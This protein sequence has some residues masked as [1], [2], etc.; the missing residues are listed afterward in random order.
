MRQTNV[1]NFWKSII[2]DLFSK[3]NK[4]LAFIPIILIPIFFHFSKNSFVFSALNSLAILLIILLKNRKFNKYFD[5]ILTFMFINFSFLILRVENYGNLIGIL[6]GLVSI[7]SLFTYYNELFILWSIGANYLTG[8]I[9]VLSFVF[10]YYEPNFRFKPN[11]KFIFI[12]IV[13]S[14]F[15]LLWLNSNMSVEIFSAKETMKIICDKNAKAKPL[16]KIAFI[17]SIAANISRFKS[18]LKVY[19][20]I[21]FVNGYFSNLKTSSHL[22]E[23]ENS[24][25]MHF[26]SNNINF[27]IYPHHS[28]Y[29]PNPNGSDLPLPDSSFTMNVAKGEYESFQLL[30][31]LKDDLHD[32]SIKF[33]NSVFSNSN[34]KCYQA[35]WIN[36]RPPVYTTPRSG[37]Y[38]DP[39]LTMEFD[40]ISKQ[41][42]E[43]NYTISIPK[44]KVN[45]FW[46]SLH[47]PE[48][49]KKGKYVL[50]IEIAAK[51]SK[52]EIIN[53]KCNININVY[54]V[55]YPKNNKLKTGFSFN[56]ELYQWYFGIYDL[57]FEAR[58][59]IYEFFLS[60]RATP[61]ELN[62]YGSLFPPY[63]DWNYLIARGAKAFCVGYYRPLTKIDTI[64][65]P[66]FDKQ[67]R[68]DIDFLNKSSLKKYAYLFA[69]DE[70]N[71]NIHNQSE[72]HYENMFKNL[73][74]YVRGIDKTI[75]ISVTTELNPKL[76]DYIDYWMPINIYYTPE[77]AK[78]AIK[79]DQEQWW[80]VTMS[81]T[82]P[83]PTF[84]IDANAIEPRILFWQGSK[85][86]IDGF[87]YYETILWQ[88][89][90]CWA[91]NAPVGCPAEIADEPKI[92]EALKQGKRWP[93]IP[94]NSYTWTKYNG[95]G[96]LI[97]PGV[98]NEL[99]P[100][101]R[102]VNIRDGI[103]DFELLNILKEKLNSNPNQKIEKELEALYNLTPD[104]INYINNPEKLL[105]NKKKLLELLE[106]I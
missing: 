59:K 6:K 29:K 10:F 58:K 96:Q 68:K 85:Y 70:M 33:D 21:S 41:F 61:T 83:Y 11:A 20:P 44:N 39:L 34:I 37:E 73:H 13:L 75:P 77:K 3:E 17:D 66:K 67:F 15:S 71:F 98:K 42:K 24:Y 102:F 32:I 104:H 1:L 90:V 87:K 43:K 30:S 86:N 80:S 38:I 52:N 101:I 22:K 48:N 9:I 63:E 19:N 46:I 49:I 7:E 35:G 81:T 53:Q 25:K 105:D 94:W 18:N 57:K 40:S 76:S 84:F 51:N 28:I 103:E 27:I 89:N 36:C 62:R 82:P 78:K 69:F 16:Q 72:E 45:S 95:D 47:I 88:S 4:Y 64:S 74:Q 14:V 92:I 91:K 12:S 5:W 99:L 31:Y 60:M 55:S 93:E 2:P 56:Y 8:I 100:S 26:P 65:F 50:P 23:I 106:I 97:Y 54:N 79:P